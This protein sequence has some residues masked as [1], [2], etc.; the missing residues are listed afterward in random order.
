[1]EDQVLNVPGIALGLAG[2]LAIFLY[3]MELMTDALK[4]VAGSRMK[5]LLA[6]LT[7]TRFKGVLA[8]TF[9]TAVIQS[10]SVT[11]VLLVGFV[12]AGLM[13]L[14]QSIGVIMGASI[15]T[16]IT[17]QIVAFKVTKLALVAIIVGFAMRFVSERDNTQQYGLMLL[18]FGFVFFGMNLMGE[19]TGPL[20][21]YEPFIATM[22]GMDRPWLAILMSALFTA[23]VQSSSAT[24]G[25]IIVLASQGFITIE[26][27][28]A[29]VL[30]ANIGTCVT[31][32]F[33]ALGKPVAA[34]Q[35]ALVHV[36]F[37]VAGV[38][39]WYAFI[40]QLATWVTHVAP[41]AE[42][43]TGLAKAAAE[44]PRQIAHAHT[45]FN[46]ANTVLFIWFTPL[47]AWVART[48]VPVRPEGAEG[49]AKPRFLDDLVLDAP[50]LALDRVRL[51]LG[52][53][54]QRVVEMVQQ[55][56]PA[57]IGGVSPADL[58][59]L[60][61]MDED[62]D[63]LHG[64]VVSY[65]GQLSK[66]TMQE[67]ESGLL[68]DYLAIANNFESMADIIETNV[69]DAA[70]DA[71][72]QQVEM[73]AETGV[74]FRALWSKVVWAVERAAQAV[75]GMDEEAAL[76]VIAA[77]EEVNALTARLEAHLLKRLTADAPRRQETFRAESTLIESLKRIYYFAKRVGK[78]VAHGVG[79]NGEGS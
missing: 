62:V 41:T 75:Y 38:V 26:T 33:A 13:T 25:V 45:T 19:A 20:R 14:E 3:G 18:G 50:A 60:A 51:E 10:S 49:R 11:T 78:S 73:S 58:R 35:T 54:A 63:A 37:N 8:G 57:I 36:I 56:P 28:I 67:R 31:A 42:G 77:K 39:L 7:T 16:T 66:E 24:T 17:A 30:G 21:T 5:G 52:R 76:E 71:S 6:R 40:P 12:S 27:G 48:L 22:Q 15:G 74:L 29:F 79:A 32:M 70:H 61:D 23:I 55:A 43:L 59:R 65:L 44:T 53:I 72:R 69:V 2:G 34:K 4:V 46:V 1:M 68:R 47:F 64:A 9:V